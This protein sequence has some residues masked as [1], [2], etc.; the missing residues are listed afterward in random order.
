M[1]LLGDMC[2]GFHWIKFGWWKSAQPIECKVY[3][4]YVILASL[5]KKRQRNKDK[6]TAMKMGKAS[7]WLLARKTVNSFL[8]TTHQS[9]GLGN[10]VQLQLSGSKFTADHALAT[11]QPWSLLLCHSENMFLTVKGICSNFG[12]G[13]KV[14]YKKYMPFLQNFNEFKNSLR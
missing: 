12:Q 14:C 3:T 10:R 8:S 1:L 11:G 6:I 13:K 2:L 7:L 5:F 9:A 4:D